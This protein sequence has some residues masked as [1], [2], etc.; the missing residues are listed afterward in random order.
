MID[1]TNVF[2]LILCLVMGLYAIY[3]IL[4]MAQLYREQKKEKKK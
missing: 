4:T 2:N 3:C 1:A